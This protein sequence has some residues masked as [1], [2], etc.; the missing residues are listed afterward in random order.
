MALTLN[1]VGKK[2]TPTKKKA[3]AKKKTA[4]KSAAPKKKVTKKTKTVHKAK[5]VQAKKTSKSKAESVKK[6]RPWQTPEEMEHIEELQTRKATAGK[7]KPKTPKASPSK[8][9]VNP[10][11]MELAGK[12]LPQ[13]VVEVLQKLEGIKNDCLA[14][15]P[16]EVNAMVKDTWV[17][18]LQ[19][20][21]KIKIPMPGFLTHKEKK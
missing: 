4:A 11:R 2:K 9:S 18:K 17:T 3:A 14:Q 8:P 7:T 10:V 1:D 20:Y 6:V 12:V 5:K 13:E 21:P 19:V 16:P 15:L